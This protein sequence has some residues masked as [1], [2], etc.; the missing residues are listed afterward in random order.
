MSLEFLAYLEAESAREC[1]GAGGCQESTV[2]K[3]A[4]VVTVTAAALCE[5][6]KSQRATLLMRRVDDGLSQAEELVCV[7][8]AYAVV[9]DAPLGMYHIGYLRGFEGA[10]NG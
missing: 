5:R 3:W 8:C 10:G 7:H 4:Q 9:R 2:L 1:H 6:C